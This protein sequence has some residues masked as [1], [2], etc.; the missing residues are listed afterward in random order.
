MS[1]QI[2]TL[3]AGLSLGGRV[4]YDNA[5][6]CQQAGEVIMAAL[7]TGA[8]TC[9]LAA[10]ETG[11]SVTAAVLMG[12]QRYAIS[13]GATLS[14]THAPERLVAILAASNLDD[15]FAVARH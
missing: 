10:L 2:K 12:W 15:V 1:H 9:D 11:S 5:S 7:E 13:R 3:G 14:L 8:W 6:A 4:D